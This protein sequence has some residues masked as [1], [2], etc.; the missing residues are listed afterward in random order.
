MPTLRQLEYL[1]AIAD[2]GHFGRAAQTVH[3]SQPT[4][5]QQLKAMEHRLNVTL[6]ERGMAGAALTPVGREIADRARRVL[7]DVKDLRAAARRAR[8][9]LAGMI[10]FGTTPTLG[11]YILPQI[12]AELHRAEPDLK[13]YIREGIPDDQR[14]DLASGQ[15][16]M[17]LG[18]MP[19]DGGGITVEPLFREQLYLVAPQDHPLVGERAVDRKRLTGENVLSMDRRHAYH[20]QTVEICAEL[21]MQLLRDYEGT[22]LDSLQQ[23]V[24]SGLGLCLLPKCYLRS[25]AGGLSGIS[26]LDIKDWH[27]Y[28]SIGAA[29]RTAA[30]DGETFHK[31]ARQI[32]AH[33]APLNNA[34]LVV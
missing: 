8:E 11:P 9:G 21:G 6:V 3:V 2:H 30:V 16:D 15:L 26:I 34:D 23:M 17:V 20:R 24:A 29:W 33:V 19:L 22:S 4:L 28:R 18:P 5:S 12:V 25:E 31:I 10:R 14:L 7:L 32:E 13:L 1:V 27:P